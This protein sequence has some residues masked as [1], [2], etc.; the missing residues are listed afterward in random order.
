MR[1]ATRSAV[2]MWELLLPSSPIIQMTFCQE[3]ANS[4]VHG[5]EWHE[6]NGNIHKIAPFEKEKNILTFTI[7][8]GEEE[9]KN[10]VTAF[11]N[12]F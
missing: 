10:A 3:P 1:V 7:L 5:R 2:I 6:K 12:K 11:E 8:D 4:L 9:I